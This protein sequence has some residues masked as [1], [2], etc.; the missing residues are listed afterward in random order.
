MHSISHLAAGFS[1]CHIGSKLSWPKVVMPS[2]CLCHSCRKEASTAPGAGVMAPLRGPL[3]PA[4]S[5]KPP[6]EE[7]VKL[8]AAQH[9]LCA[10]CC[11]T[12]SQNIFLGLLDQEDED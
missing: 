1:I 3:S 12:S 11:S 10:T 6:A 7:K 8:A 2:M 5:V 4:A 9:L